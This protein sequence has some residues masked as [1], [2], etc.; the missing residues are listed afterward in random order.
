[1]RGQ[2][3]LGAMMML[4]GGRIFAAAE[5]PAPQIP[6]PVIPDAKFVITAY[7]AV[8]DG[9][10]PATDAIQKTIDACA[11]AGGGHVVVPAGDY[12]I[13]P[14]HL[15]SN[16]DLHLDR[17]ATLKLMNDL[18]KYPKGNKGYENAITADACHDLAL[19]GEGTIDGQ[20]QPWWKLYAKRPNAAGDRVPPNLPHRPFMVVFSNCQ[21]LH[22]QGVTLKNSPS[23]HLVPGDCQFVTIED[24][25]IQAPADAPNT[26]AM[27]PSGHDFLIR[28]CTFDVGD[29]DI[30][31]KASHPSANGPSCENF[32]ITDC[33][34]LHGHGLSIGGQTTG[35]RRG[36][37][38][39]DCTF[40]DTQ[41]GIRMKAGRGAGGMVE[42]VT[43]D[44]LRMKNVKIGIY[45]TSYYPTAPKAPEDDPAQSMNDRTPVWRN[46]HITDVTGTG[47]DQAGLLIGLAEAPIDGLTLT[48]VNLS[49]KHGMTVINA[50]NVRL[51]HSTIT[52]E[53]GDPLILHKAEVQNDN[54]PAAP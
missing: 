3:L 20:G 17:G 11:A 19:T 18:D 31:V 52:V 9:I 53:K 48:N 50:K 12:L 46:I 5:S 6:P 15:A 38:V 54:A 25:T 40:Q 29:D 13:G 30:A 7:G 35:G 1:M 14:F 51:V 28:H 43:Y 33:T 37:H 22:V 26:D 8:G 34:L 27:D 47:L 10:T 45:I 32:T 16:L 39:S 2:L 41:A 42:D 21:R 49:A 44:R 24:V 4:C 36:R 23:F